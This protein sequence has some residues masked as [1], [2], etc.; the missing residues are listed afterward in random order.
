MEDEVH[1]Y[2]RRRVLAIGK[3]TRNERGQV[4]RIAI[5]RFESLPEN[6]NERAPVSE[7]LGIDPDWLAGQNV[8]D[9]V[10]EVRR[11]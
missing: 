1:R 4:V 11:A 8:D 3:V 6:D 9:Y 10:R 2:W 5:E 7:L